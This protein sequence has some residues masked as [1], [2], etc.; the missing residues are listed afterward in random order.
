V[1]DYI[2]MGVVIV[3]LAALVWLWPNVIHEPMHYLALKVQGVDGHINVDWSFPPH[4]SIT[5][6]GKVAGVFGG[7][8]YL[9][10]PSL[11]SV[12]ILAMLWVTR[13]YASLLTHVVLPAYLTFDLT[14]NIVKYARPE[15]DF[16]FLSALPVAVGIILC[17]LSAI[18]GM[19]VIFVGLQRIIVRGEV[20]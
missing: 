14:L 1:V 20:A 2:K 19:A 8:L 13:K 16:H 17:M 10:A 11:L 4:P 6:Q 7:L 18:I 5:K 3:A 15:S 12:V 9:L